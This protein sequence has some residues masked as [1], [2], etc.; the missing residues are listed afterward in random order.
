MTRRYGGEEFGQVFATF[1]V[2]WGRCPIQTFPE[3][4]GFAGNVIFNFLK[5]PLEEVVDV[6][7]KKDY[8]A[9]NE[10]GMES[11]TAI[12]HS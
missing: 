4:E 3:S 11:A 8:G 6:S 2:Q 5:E 7:A 10:P 12:F 1:L 9:H